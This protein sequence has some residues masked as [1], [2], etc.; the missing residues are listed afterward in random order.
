MVVR[1]GRENK[2]KKEREQAE[3]NRR[4]SRRRDLRLDYLSALNPK[5]M[6]IKGTRK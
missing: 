5:L 1:G 3:G 2:E 6:S 4:R